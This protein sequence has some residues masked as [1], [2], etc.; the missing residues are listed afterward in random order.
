MSFY[1]FSYS[2][3]KRRKKL[4][5]FWL[6]KQSA[7]MQKKF[8]HH[9]KTYHSLKT[10]RILQKSAKTGLLKIHTRAR[11]SPFSQSRLRTVILN[12]QFSPIQ[13]YVN[14]SK[15][16]NPVSLSVTGQQSVGCLS[17][18]CTQRLSDNREFM[19]VDVLLGSHFRQSQCAENVRDNYTILARF[20]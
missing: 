5:K 6:V 1:C 3:K 16:E 7:I 10:L 19:K 4:H 11:C 2:I 14:F 18:A 12:V 9:K 17:D 13:A 8:A 15:I 20:I